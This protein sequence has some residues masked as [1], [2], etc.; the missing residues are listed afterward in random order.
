MVW[1]LILFVDN[2]F[3]LFNLF[4]NFV[5]FKNWH[6][7]FII[8]SKIWHKRRKRKTNFI[9]QITGFKI[10]LLYLYQLAL[11]SFN[12]NEIFNYTRPSINTLLTARWSCVRLR[13][14]KECTPINDTLS[15]PVWHVSIDPLPHQVQDALILESIS[16]SIESN[17]PT[18]LTYI[19]LSITEASS[20]NLIRISVQP[21]KK[22]IFSCLR[23][24]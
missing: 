10:T 5:F 24:P 18:T 2:S 20:W 9:Y 12:P 15:S 8:F 17:F 1:V 7:F 23:V 4:E 11:N 6:S 14:E 21:R 22:K 3:F 13:L 19:I 16:R